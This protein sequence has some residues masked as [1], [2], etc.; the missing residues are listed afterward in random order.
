MTL[1]RPGHADLAGTLKYG[2]DDAR[3]ALERA[4]ARQTA[5]TVAAGARREGAAR[6]DRDRG[7]RLDARDGRRRRGEGG[8][9]HGRRDRRSS[10][11]R[12]AAGPRLVRVEGGP[13]RRAARC[14]A[15]GHPGREGSRDRRRVRARPRARLGRSRRDLPRRAGLL[16]RDEPGGRPRGRRVERR[17]DRRP[18]GD[19]AAADAHA[20]AA[21]RRPR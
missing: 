5:V 16:P 2:L 18:R 13:A 10:R 17:R 7:R 15:D 1:P 3:N 11:A 12:R 21:L 4:S 6:A 19:E 14:G 9:R 8:P 20:P